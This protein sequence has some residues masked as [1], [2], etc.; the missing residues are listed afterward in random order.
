[1]GNGWKFWVYLFFLILFVITCWMV[2]IAVDSK[3]TEGINWG[4]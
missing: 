4:G 1:M 3:A 2:M